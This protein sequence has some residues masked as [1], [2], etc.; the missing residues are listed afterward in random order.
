MSSRYGFASN[1]RS[2]PRLQEAPLGRYLV[3]ITAFNSRQIKFSKTRRKGEWFFKI[4]YRIIRGQSA[5]AEIKVCKGDLHEQTIFQNFESPGLSNRDLINYCGAVYAADHDLTSNP[6]ER[7]IVMAPEF[8]V[9]DT[10]VC[11]EEYIDQQKVPKPGAYLSLNRTANETKG[12][13]IFPVHNWSPMS[14]ETRA[15]IVAARN[16]RQQGAQGSQGTQGTTQRAQSGTAQRQ[17]SARAQDTQS[18]EAI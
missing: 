15:A 8:K 10:L 14:E 16:A 5:S 4:Q 18:D 3:E 13:K 7:L 9:E 6:A 11:V 1:E 17:T 2:E 12:G